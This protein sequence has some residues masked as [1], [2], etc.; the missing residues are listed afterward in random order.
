[1]YL[2]LR[3]MI[4]INKQKLLGSGIDPDLHLNLRVLDLQAKVGSSGGLLVL[5]LDLDEGLSSLRPGLN[6]DRIREPGE[7]LLLGQK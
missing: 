2:L 1:M 7:I 5:H 6:G 3:N 4:V